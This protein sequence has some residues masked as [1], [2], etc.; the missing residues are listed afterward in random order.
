M[1]YLL[2]IFL[3]STYLFLS[4]GCQ[5]S[6]KI[7]IDYCQMLANDQS[8]INRDFSDKDKWQS[9]RKKRSAIFKHNFELLMD[10]AK[11]DGLPKTG[12]FE[13]FPDSCRFN[14]ISLT[15][16][17]IAQSQ[18]ELLFEKN[19]ILLLEKEIKSGNLHID[20]INS[21]FRMI[22]SNRI[23]LKRLGKEVQLAIQKWE[24]ESLI[25]WNAKPN[26]NVDYWEL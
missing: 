15:F 17:H 10:K 6:S 12:T 25:D 3:I 20:I 14:A 11:L 2:S 7:S 21:A 5:F 1:K 16:I 23:F 8:Y 24:A 13:D 19:I 22:N 26:I 9:D 4:I 18:P